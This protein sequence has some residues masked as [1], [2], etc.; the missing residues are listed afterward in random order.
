M[1]FKIDYMRT[2]RVTG[3]IKA[4][5]TLILGSPPIEIRDMRLIEGKNGTFVAFPSKKGQRTDGTEAYFD[6]VS[7]QRGSDKEPTQEALDFMKEVVDAAVAEYTRKTGDALDTSKDEG[8][9]DDLP[10]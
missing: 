2:Q 5:F 8:S 1:R 10:F 4:Y 7:V 6:I 9:D 3:K